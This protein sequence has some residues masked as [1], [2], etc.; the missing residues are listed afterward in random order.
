[1]PVGSR[2]NLLYGLALPVLGRRCRW[3]TVRVSGEAQTDLSREVARV[4]QRNRVV[5]GCVRMIRN[6]RL[7]ESYCAGNATL[8]PCVPVTTDTLF[9]TAS[10]AKLACALLVMR[11]H[12]LGLL[13]VDEDISAFW[14]SPVRNPA[15]PET[16]IPLAS[17]LS[18]TSGM[19][20]SP[21]YFSSYRN[22]ISTNEILADGHCFSARKPYETFRYSNFA[23]GLIGC[24]LEK[25][26]GESLEAL[27]QRELFVPL[28]ACASFDLGT[29]SPA[30]V[31]SSYRV[32]PPSRGPAFDAPAR[33]RTAASL[34]A[35]DPQAHYLLAS[36]GLFLTAEALTR[37]A[38]PLLNG[39]LVDGVPFLSPASVARM[40]TPV[41]DWP[42]PAVRMRHGM[43]LLEVD[44]RAVFPR[45]LHGHQG[46]AYGAVNGVFFD[47]DGNGFASLNSGA[48]ERRVG[49]LSCLNRDLIGVC[50]SG[51]RV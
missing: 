35:P 27:A 51:G 36:G 3:Q 18:H 29:L 2:K 28:G 37:L 23:A 20:D 40:T 12:T 43:G 26:F 10:V 13:D 1:M 17:L 38:L 21:L 41:T 8:Y 9:R 14:G 16:P 48:S 25:R 42:E 11:L 34:A 47:D 49:H 33:I 45:R 31:A 32:L 4:L 50:L 5:G 6:G 15:H 7:A 44:D 22:V 19:V 39:G 30:S 46:F 24:L